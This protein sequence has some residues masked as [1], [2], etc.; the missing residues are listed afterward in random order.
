MK[1]YE[2]DADYSDIDLLRLVFP[3]DDH[4]V[5]KY[6]SCGIASDGSKFAAS[7]KDKIPA[8]VSAAIGGVAG[9]HI[10]GPIGGEIGFI[11]GVIVGEISREVVTPLIEKLIKKGE[12]IPQDKI[13][14]EFDDIAYSE[15]LPLSELFKKYFKLMKKGDEIGMK[16]DKTRAI[17]YYTEALQCALDIRKKSKNFI[18]ENWFNVTIIADVYSKL[19]SIH[20]DNTN[21][22]DA[23]KNFYDAD[24]WLKE[25]NNDDIS[26]FDRRIEIC[27]YSMSNYMR[28][29]KEAN[30]FLNGDKYK[31]IDKTFTN[32]ICDYIQK[33]PE[34]NSFASYFDKR[35][36][37]LAQDYSIQ[38]SSYF[39]YNIYVYDKMRY[40]LA[41]GRFMAV[42][43]MCDFFSF[44]KDKNN[45]KA[46]EDVEKR[47]LKGLNLIIEGYDISFL[48]NIEYKD[49]LINDY[50]NSED[51][52]NLYL[53]KTLARNFTLLLGLGYFA[54]DEQLINRYMQLLI[55]LDK[56]ERIKNCRNS[57]DIM[58]GS[59]QTAIEKVLKPYNV[60]IPP[61][62]KIKEQVDKENN[63]I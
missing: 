10:A 24:E 57:Y 1:F 7:I 16:Y 36:I 37:N 40:L 27:S 18:N 46:K 61:Y 22:F 12:K 54:S 6:F 55:K 31:D 45:I 5:M 39:Y 53:Q 47:L 25:Y 26:F 28:N 9:N 62:D 60:N 4:W 29:I 15:Y 33:L 35:L 11:T 23:S 43:A 44:A 59:V 20:S 51:Y 13:K 48:E 63:E 19:A 50:L 52:Y 49:N 30:N 2:N 32:Q 42:R 38:K 58:W 14:K 3:E 17:E 56:K 41:I 8:I 21:F 34:R